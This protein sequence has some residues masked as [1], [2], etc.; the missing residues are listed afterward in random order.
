MLEFDFVSRRMMAKNK[1]AQI[2]GESAL[3]F[4]DPHFS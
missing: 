2:T 1:V 3:V 4:G